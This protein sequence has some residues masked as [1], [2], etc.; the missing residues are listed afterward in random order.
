MLESY[1]Q[2]A[3]YGSALWGTIEEECRRQ[4]NQIELIASKN[5]ANLRVMQAHGPVLTNEYAEGCLAALDKPLQ[6]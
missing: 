1:L 6:A 2:I 4:E 3:N 5:H